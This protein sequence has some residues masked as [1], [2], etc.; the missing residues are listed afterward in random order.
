M[1]NSEGLCNELMARCT[2]YNM[3][4]LNDTNCKEGQDYVIGY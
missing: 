4:Y 3:K 1:T 2:K